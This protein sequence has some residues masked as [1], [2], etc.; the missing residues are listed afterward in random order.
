M[1][2]AAKWC[3]W[4]LLFQVFMIQINTQEEPH[5]FLS[6]NYRRLGLFSLRPRPVQHQPPA[7]VCAGLARLPSS[8][9]T[10]RFVRVCP[11]TWG[12][13]SVQGSSLG[14]PLRLSFQRTPGWEG[15]GVSHQE[16]KLPLL[17]DPVPCFHPM[18]ILPPLG[19][20][21]RL[22]NTLPAIMLCG[23]SAQM[24]YLPFLRRRCV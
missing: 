6:T 14:V 12:Q 2:T 8:C 16:G 3:L 15:F 17:Q 5:P 11:G 13:E 21:Q 22:L 9:L 1:A 23:L 18:E 7:G 20:R 24:S 19:G 4:S 10:Q